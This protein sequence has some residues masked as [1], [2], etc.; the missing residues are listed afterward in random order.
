MDSLEIIRQME[1]DPGLRAQ[2]RA[3]LLGDNFLER[4]A[5]AAQ[6]EEAQS[7]T[8]TAIDRLAAAVDRF[9]EVVGGPVETDAVALLEWLAG[10]RGWQLPEPPVPFDFDGETGVVA[11]L[12]DGER[13]FR[14]VV[15]AKARLRLADVARFSAGLPRL[16][17]AL[18]IEEP[19]LA[20]LCGL[21]V[22]QEVESAA[23]AAGLGALDYRGE[24]VAPPS[25]AT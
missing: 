10:E 21:C 14:I 7:P 20:Y 23:S 17:A 4:P 13:R 2:L 1:G 9:W 11:T 16:V 18:A 12:I 22:F 15:G 25:L 5:F 24:R 19:Y 3:V 8:E 6:P